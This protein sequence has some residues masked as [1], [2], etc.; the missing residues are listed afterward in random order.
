MEPRLNLDSDIV[1]E[2]QNV[3]ATCRLYF[4]PGKSIIWHIERGKDQLTLRISDFGSLYEYDPTRSL[5]WKLLTVGG[6]G[7]PTCRFIF[8]IL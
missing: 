8:Q 4:G 7:S 1:K 6:P 2:D 5:P 3:T